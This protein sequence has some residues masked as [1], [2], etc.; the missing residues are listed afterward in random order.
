MSLDFIAA[1]ATVPLKTGPSPPISPRHLQD[2]LGDLVDINNDTQDVSPDCYN[3]NLAT[4]FQRTM[5][6][7][8]AAP[9]VKADDFV[10]H[11]VDLYQTDILPQIRAPGCRVVVTCDWLKELQTHRYTITL[12]LA[13]VH[14]VQ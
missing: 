7:N 5:T 11:V 2:I 1:T 4:R 14:D 6:Y 13:T 8:H 3:Y 10:Q 12:F 9:L